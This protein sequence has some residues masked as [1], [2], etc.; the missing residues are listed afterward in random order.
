LSKI[1]KRA[2]KDG[3]I[4]YLAL[5]NYRDLDR[6]IHC[7]WVAHFEKGRVSW[8]IVSSDVYTDLKHHPILGIRIR[9]LAQSARLASTTF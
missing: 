9:T 3:F 1:N 2:K 6:R 7:P 4:Q 5:A 8:C